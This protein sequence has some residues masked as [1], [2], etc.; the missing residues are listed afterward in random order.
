M[1]G[2]HHGMTLGLAAM[3]TQVHEDFSIMPVD[4]ARRPLE[5]IE[6]ID[7]LLESYDNHATILAQSMD[8]QSVLNRLFDE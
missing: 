4:F 5:E 7:E 8:A 3:S 1:Q 6:D 2:V